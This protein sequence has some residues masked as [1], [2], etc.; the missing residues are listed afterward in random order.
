MQT[1][2]MCRGE[3]GRGE[4]VGSADK[5]IPDYRSPD[6][7]LQH[8]ETSLLIQGN[9]YTLQVVCDSFKIIPLL[10]AIKTTCIGMVPL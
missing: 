4:E 10:T 8:W 1:L 9:K 3:G 5:I 7:K 2:C 6:L